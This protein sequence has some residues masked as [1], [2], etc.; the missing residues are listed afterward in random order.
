[1]LVTS[2]QATNRVAVLYALLLVSAMQHVH[3]LL[4]VGDMSN[5]NLDSNTITLQRP[6][7]GVTLVAFVRNSN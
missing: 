1:M 3:S 6:T 2:I 4:L 5:R 7:F